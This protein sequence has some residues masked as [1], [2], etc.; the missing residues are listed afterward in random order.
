MRGKRGRE[1]GLFA[2]LSIGSRGI[3]RKCDTGTMLSIY[4]PLRSIDFSTEF[5]LY[6]SEECLTLYSPDIYFTRSASF[7]ATV[8]NHDISECGLMWLL[9]SFLFGQ[10]RVMFVQ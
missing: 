6:Y 10:S 8:E 7:S 9:G 5:L 4:S 1:T 3:V 2:L